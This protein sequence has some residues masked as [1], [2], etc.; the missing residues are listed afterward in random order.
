MGHKYQLNMASIAG[1]IN[2]AVHEQNSGYTDGF[3]GWGYK[4][5]LYRLKWIL[6]DALRRSPSYLFEDDW[7]REQEQ[8]KIIDILSKK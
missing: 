4:Q 8:K 1:Q 6:E 7:L 3:V 2:S 5:D